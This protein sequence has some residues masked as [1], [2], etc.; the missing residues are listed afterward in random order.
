MNGIVRVTAL[1]FFILMVHAASAAVLP[2]TVEEMSAVSDD[3]VHGTVME[4]E[5]DIYGGKIITR[6]ELAIHDSAKGTAGKGA[7]MT[8]YTLGGKIGPLA[9]TAPGMP[10]LEKDEEVVLFLETPN[11]SKLKAKGAKID[12][13]SPMNNTPLIV[14]G[15]QGKFSV[16]KGIEK[17][18]APGGKA[19][20]VEREMIFRQTPGRPASLNG[21][22]TVDEFMSSLK[23]LNNKSLP[24]KTVIRDIGAKQSV[25]VPV[26]DKKNTALRA[27]DPFGGESATKGRNLKLIRAPKNE[28]E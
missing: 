16:V 12:E 10:T 4:S 18:D 6:H 17:H 22:P 20:E 1:S 25:E 21:M 9:A 15:F 24:V 27:F 3:I 23:T 19:L 7:T 28:N 14:G 5:S 13:K 2:L 11:L 26:P 8:L